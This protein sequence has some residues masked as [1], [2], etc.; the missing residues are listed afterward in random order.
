[1]EQLMRV[2]SRVCCAFVQTVFWG[3]KGQQAR[4]MKLNA[5]SSKQ[6]AALGRAGSLAHL[7]E[8]FVGGADKM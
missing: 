4:P 2:I 8:K 6:L 7:P 1:M 5:Q 3:H